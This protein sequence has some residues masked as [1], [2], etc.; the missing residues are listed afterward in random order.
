MTAKAPSGSDGPQRLYFRSTFVRSVLSVEY[1]RGRAVFRSDS[2]S[3]ISILKEVLTKEATTRKLQIAVDVDLRIESVPHLLTLLRPQLDA[4]FTLHRKAALIPALKEIAT[5]ELGSLA[6]GSG[7]GLAANLDALEAFLQPSWI[8][9]LRDADA[10]E[11]GLKAA[12]R[13]LDFL[14]GIVTDLFVDKH[15]LQGRSAQ[16]RVPSL[17][18]I[19]ENYS[20]EKLIAAFDE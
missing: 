17:L 12:P 8:E 19:L 2:L 1:E 16:T 18:A 10:I 14:R 9:I 15:K 5:H 11:A 6:T 3:A 7:G 4:H 13:H 20:F